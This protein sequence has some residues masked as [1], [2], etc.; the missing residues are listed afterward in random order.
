MEIIQIIIRFLLYV[1]GHK[2]LF[3]I[4][5]EINKIVY[6]KLPNNV[7]NKKCQCKIGC[8]YHRGW[9]NFIHLKEFGKENIGFNSIE[10]NQILCYI[11]NNRALNKIMEIN[12]W[13]VP[14]LKEMKQHT[15]KTLITE[16]QRNN[17]EICYG[18]NKNYGTDCIAIRL[19]TEYNEPLSYDHI[20]STIIHEL[21][22]NNISNHN[23]IF[24]NKEEELR[25]YFNRNN[26]YKI[27]WID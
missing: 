23:K 3:Q 9:D 27:N 21:T 12:N 8:K 22:H 14:I 16:K 10:K 7:F 15:E 13:S 26:M 4:D 11:A 24:K 5:N 1:F 25:N 19:K 18:Y 6:Q 17:L 20:I 2:M